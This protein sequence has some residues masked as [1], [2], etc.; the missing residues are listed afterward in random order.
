MYTKLLTT[1]AMLTCLRGMAWADDVNLPQ[2]ASDAAQSSA[3]VIPGRGATMNT[4]QAKFGAPTERVAAVGHPPIA[5]WEYP[6]FI[7]YFE[8]ER[9]IHSVVR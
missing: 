8:G 5:R 3:I 2:G 4:V 6:N 1:V 9:V 7:V